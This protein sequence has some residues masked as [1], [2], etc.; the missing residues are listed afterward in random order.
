MNRYKCQSV[1]YRWALLLFSWFL[2]WLLST[3]HFYLTWSEFPESDFLF[4]GIIALPASFAS[5]PSLLASVFGELFPNIIAIVLFISYWPLIIYIIYKFIK[6]G[7]CLTFLILLIV[8]LLSCYQCHYLAA[9][10][11]GI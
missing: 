11:S 4:Y 1:R 7:K 10:I 5:L 6:T 8:T 9:G 3:T 2:G